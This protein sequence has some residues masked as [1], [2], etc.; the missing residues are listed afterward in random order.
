MISS[1]PVV[2]SQ[3]WNSVHGDKPEEVL[4]DNMAWMLKC[5]EESGIEPFEREIRIKTSFYK[6]EA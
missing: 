2:S 6:P 3:Y 4:A 1:M 5:R